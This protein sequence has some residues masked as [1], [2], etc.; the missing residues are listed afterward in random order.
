MCVHVWTARIALEQRSMAQ[1][2]EAWSRALWV[3][4]VHVTTLFS[5][6]FLLYSKN[7]ASTTLNERC[8]CAVVQH[9]EEHLLRRHTPFKVQCLPREAAWSYVLNF[10]YFCT[11]QARHFLGLIA[12]DTCSF[13]WSLQR[14]TPLWRSAND[15]SM[16]KYCIIKHPG[17]KMYNINFTLSTFYLCTISVKETLKWSIFLVCSINYLFIIIKAP[18]LWEKMLVTATTCWFRRIN[19]GSFCNIKIC[20]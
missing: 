19:V 9:S 1:L 15:I 17:I 8:S 6:S 13:A 11:A 7:I 14:Q 20:G 2:S 5:F 3:S 16:S 18:R 12:T 10:N 4:H